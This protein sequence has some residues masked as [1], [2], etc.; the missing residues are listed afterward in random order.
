MERIPRFYLCS[1]AGIAL[2]AAVLYAPNPPQKFRPAYD[3]ERFPV[4]AMSSVPAGSDRI[5]TG[6]AWAGYLIYEQYPARKVFVDG[7]SDF[8]GDSVEKAYGDILNAKP[9]WQQLL[10]H[11]RI[12]TVLLPPDNTLVATLRLSPG[13]EPVYEDKTAVVFRAVKRSTTNAG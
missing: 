2:L 3:P 1:A 12:D 7:R 4:K 13:W 8:Y 10:Q 9:G 5:F 11:Y 6:D